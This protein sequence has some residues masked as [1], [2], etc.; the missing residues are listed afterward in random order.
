MTSPPPPPRFFL[1]PPPDLARF[2][3]PPPPSQPSNIL[4]FRND[5]VTGSAVLPPSWPGRGSPPGGA[6]FAALLP[7]LL[8]LLPSPR[9]RSLAYSQSMSVGLGPAPWQPGPAK[10][11]VWRGVMEKEWPFMLGAG[12]KLFHLSLS[13]LYSVSWGMR[14]ISKAV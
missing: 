11:V 10:A 9:K 14:G 13:W 1:L 12:W 3:S 6:S 8:L 7:S 2:S 5:V 4:R